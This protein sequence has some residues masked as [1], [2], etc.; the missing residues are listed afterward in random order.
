MVLNQIPKPPVLRRFVH[1]P[2]NQTPTSHVHLCTHPCTSA[3]TDEQCAQQDCTCPQAFYQ[4]NS[5]WGFARLPHQDLGFDHRLGLKAWQP[6]S[7]RRFAPC[8]RK[9]CAVSLVYLSGGLRGCAMASPSGRDDKYKSTSGRTYE[10]PTD[11]NGTDEEAGR[12]SSRSS[13]VRQNQKVEANPKQPRD[14]LCVFV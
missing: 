8:E 12:S 2:I 1:L 9:R 3:Q 5:T 14:F 4:N 10:A 13:G 7:A 6:P 11:T